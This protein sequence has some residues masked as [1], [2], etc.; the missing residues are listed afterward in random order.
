[1][2]KQNFCFQSYVWLKHKK[3]V[4][5]YERKPP[6]QMDLCRL[7]NQLGSCK[8]YSGQIFLHHL[9]ICRFQL[10][11][12]EL[13]ALTLFLH[14]QKISC[15]FSDS[16]PHL[17]AGSEL[18]RGMSAT[19]LSFFFSSQESFHVASLLPAPWSSL[20]LFPWHVSWQVSLCGCRR[21]QHV[22]D[23][24]SELNEASTS[25][26]KTLKCSDLS[27]FIMAETRQKLE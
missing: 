21:C 23:G 15:Q 1:M 18:V 5:I 9:P 27:V 8:C 7:W 22:K 4:C 3:K 12:Y 13:P 19:F 14:Q 2:F 17:A 20:L 16:N 24:A 25:R 11:Q 26:K 6:N 10:R